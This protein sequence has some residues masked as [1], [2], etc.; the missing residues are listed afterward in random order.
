MS[1]ER[2]LKFVQVSLN[3]RSFQLNYTKPPIKDSRM[4]NQMEL[5]HMI[6]ST[7]EIE[8]TISWLRAGTILTVKGKVV[9]VESTNDYNWNSEILLTDGAETK[10][11]ILWVE[12]I[13]VQ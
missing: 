6:P 10:K 11:L 4:Y 2:N 1:D 13:E 12:S 5:L 9:N 8:K 7:K 3:G